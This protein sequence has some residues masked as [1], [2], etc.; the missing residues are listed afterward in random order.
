MAAETDDLFSDVAFLRHNSHFL[1]QA[2]FIDHHTAGQFPDP[3]GEP[4]LVFQN[5]LRRAS[6]NPFHEAANQRE[7]RRQVPL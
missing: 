5:D 7:T 1:K 4:F 3:V 2:C 6:G